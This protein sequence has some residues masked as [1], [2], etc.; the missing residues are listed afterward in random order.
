MQIADSLKEKHQTTI[1]ISVR[2]F[3]LAALL[4][5]A[6][7]VIIFFIGYLKIWWAV[8]FSTGL[9]LAI[10][11]TMREMKKDQRSIDAAKRSIEI[12]P[13]YLILMCIVIPLLLYWAGIGEFGYCL[14]DHRVRYAILNDLVKYDWPVIFD[15]STQ[16]NPVVAASL[17]SGNAAFS[18]YF[19][20]WMIPALFGKAFGLMTARI[21]LLIWA[22]LGMILVSLG[23]ALLYKRAS[24]IF[25]FCVILYAGFDTIPYLINILTKTPTTWEGWNSHL[26]IHGNYYQ[27]MNVFNQSI[28]GWII[29]ILL[30]LSN[31]GRS[32]GFLG[33]LMFCYSP[34]ATI[35]IF[36]MCICKIITTSKDKDGKRVS[37]SSI[38]KSTFTIQNLIPPIICL[39]CFGALY[40]ANPN[41]T[42]DDG[43]IW[44]FYESPLWLLKDY[45]CY[46]IFEFGIWFV[47][48]IRKHKKD[49]MLWTA[50]ITLLIL[51]V[52]KIS[53]ANDFIMRGS[54]APALAIG[55]YA[56]MFVTDNVELCRD[57]TQKLKTAIAG[58]AVIVIFLF[59]AYFPINYIFYQGL[60]TFQMHHTDAVFDDETKIIGSFGNI[61]SE[62]ELDMVKNQFY[63]YDYEN[64]V[65]FKY[66]AK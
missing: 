64:S 5:L 33:G 42:G 53:I 17:G 25:F 54:M 10:Y 34:W 45:V 57:N 58:R 43:F 52:Y 56:M 7:P 46:V 21:V 4:Y 22:S 1:S 50:F 27:L 23:A 3:F 9:I 31:D 30:L 38:A 19:V 11:L 60:I 26:F 20:F 39:I 55:L 44:N 35:G 41:A 2:S 63:V 47:M 36:P 28:P 37:V 48:V 32:V 51:P 62:E 13:S 29:T 18:Y 66:L 61:N 6:L 15:F 8:L 49:P 12:K 16:Q 24:K 14:P 65:F 59:A 40:T